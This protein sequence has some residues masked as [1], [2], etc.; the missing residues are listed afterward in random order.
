MNP[1][2]GRAEGTRFSSIIEEAQES[3]MPETPPSSPSD[4]S[5]HPTSHLL[6]LVAWLIVGIPALWGVSQTFRQALKLVQHAPPAA[7][8]NP[9]PPVK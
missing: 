8:T 1:F 2:S 4:A 3:D 6:V 7:A 5:A 9:A